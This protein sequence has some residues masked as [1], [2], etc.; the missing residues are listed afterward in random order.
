MHFVVG[1]GEQSPALPVLSGVPQGSVLGPLFF[2]IYIDNV[3]GQ[4]SPLSKLILFADDI[5]LYRIIRSSLDYLALQEDVSSIAAWVTD[6]Y[7]ALNVDKCCCMLFSKKRQPT[8]PPLSL[9]ID[10]CELA[11]VKQTKYLGV[12][13]SSEMSWTPH[14]T[15]ICAKA[16]KL[17]GL[18]YRRF[19]KWTDKHTLLAL[20][21]AYV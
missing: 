9:N 15:S 5:S 3:T 19:Y 18:L 21:I 10:G 6:N 11:M 20:Y 17:V 4:I 14:V 16:R 7:L 1:G 8:S 12:L 13:L 2:L